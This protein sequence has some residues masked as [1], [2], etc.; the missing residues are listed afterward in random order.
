[1]SFGLSQDLNTRTGMI[2]CIDAVLMSSIDVQLHKV[3]RDCLSVY[4]FDSLQSQLQ[5]K[6]SQTIMQNTSIYKCTE[7]KHNVD[8][9]RDPA[10]HTSNSADP[11]RYS[12]KDQK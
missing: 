5:S 4:V 12:N 11:C 7:P 1:M 9:R 6:W 10:A 8:R 2:R 3:L